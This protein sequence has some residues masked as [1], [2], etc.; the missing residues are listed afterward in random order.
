MSL[1]KLVVIDQVEVLELGQIQVRQATKIM[2]DGKEIGRAYHR[3]VILPGDSLDD[4]NKRVV[5]IAKAVWT[6]EV[7]SNYQK[8]ETK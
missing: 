2:E 5:A 4:Q 6:D 3:H 8:L 1:E 7:V